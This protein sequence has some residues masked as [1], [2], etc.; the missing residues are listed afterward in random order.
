[1]KRQMMQKGKLEAIEKEGRAGAKCFAGEANVKQ[2][3]CKINN[4]QEAPPPTPQ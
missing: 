2:E 1:L 4:L 3:S